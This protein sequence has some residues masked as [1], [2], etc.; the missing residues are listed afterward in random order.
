MFCVVFCDFV[1]LIRLP[2]SSKELSSSSHMKRRALFF[3]AEFQTS[4]AM[5]F[6]SLDRVKLLDWTRLFPCLP[7]LSLEIL[8][9]SFSRTFSP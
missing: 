6:P 1:L 8:D 3:P 7:R 5:I 4:V 2:P 9:V